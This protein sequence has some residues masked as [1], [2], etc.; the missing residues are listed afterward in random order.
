LIPFS[1]SHTR[2]VR[3]GNCFFLGGSTSSP[4]SSSDNGK[5]R[6]FGTLLD[7]MVAVV[8]V[9]EEQKVSKFGQYKVVEGVIVRSDQA[10]VKA[11]WL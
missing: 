9:E 3:L 4:E 10:S 11:I 7:M 8:G 5:A 6:F 2:H 1:A